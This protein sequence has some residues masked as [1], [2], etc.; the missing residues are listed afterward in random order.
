MRR[1]SV[2][3]CLLELVLV[4]LACLAA[5]A[6]SSPAEPLELTAAEAVLRALE[7]SPELAVERVRP[8]LART[9]EGEEKAKF[10]PVLIAEDVGWQSI[11]GEKLRGLG[12]L[13]TFETESPVG[14]LALEGLLPTGTRFEVEAMTE[15]SDESLDRQLVRSRVGLT[16]SQAL[17]QGLGPGVTQAR[18]RAARLDAAIS[19][20]ELR[21]FTESF[22]AVVE[23]TYWD[24]ALHR[25]RLEI[26]DEMSAMADRQVRETEDRV[27]IG[28][29]A[30]VE[31]A[32]A[33]S[34]ASLR[35]QERIDAR[36]NAEKTRLRLLRFLN[37]G[38]TDPWRQEIRPSDALV[39]PDLALDDVGLEVETALRMRP[40]SNQ[41]RLLVERSDL[42]VVRTRNG[43]LPRMDVFVTLGR[44]GYADSF[45]SSWKNLDGEYDDVL[46]GLRFEFPIRRSE[47]HAQHERSVAERT[48]A[49]KAVENLRQLVEWD[50]RTARVEVERVR[51]RI[52]A[53][54]LTRQLDEEKLDAETE[55]FAIGRASAFQVARA[56]RDL[57]RSRL[58]EAEALAEAQKALV[59][60]Y[61]LDGSLLLRRGVEAPGRSL[62]GTP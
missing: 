62:S 60:L 59:E 10:D 61:R 43:L 33:R 17:L 19:E 31:L 21:A 49:E 18:V 41:A 34:E 45:R 15:V 13:E 40:E 54:T 37:L 8:Q 23:E 35:N 53:T 42:E 52:V 12:I 38:G 39:V 14:R 20:Y 27:G 48:L 1:V 9:F 44:S 7:N 51:E 32:A 28:V 50:V 5:A 46:A 4:N 22:V 26:L 6:M 25:R 30:R 36:S 11:K 24:Y 29:S 3:R 47:S 2:R 56:Q 58:A 16:V 55:K 57:T